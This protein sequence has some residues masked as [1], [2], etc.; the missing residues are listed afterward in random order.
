MKSKD[1][2]CS[3]S[4]AVAPKDIWSELKR[5][6]K[7]NGKTVEVHVLKDSPEDTFALVHCKSAAAKLSA[8]ERLAF[9]EDVFRAYLYADSVELMPYD[10]QQLAKFRRLLN[11][12]QA[13]AS[14]YGVE[15]TTLASIAAALDASG[16]SSMADFVRSSPGW[17]Q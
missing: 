16:K 14:F 12:K 2:K 4:E 6:A 5:L 15:P 11:G 9:E 3:R 8:K 7:L 17:K 10:R 13:S 1:V